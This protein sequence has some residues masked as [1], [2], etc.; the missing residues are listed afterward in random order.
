MKKSGKQNEEESEAEA[1]EERIR[2]WKTRNRPE[3]RI[4]DV[5]SE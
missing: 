5:K 4:K 2:R 3:T 1:E